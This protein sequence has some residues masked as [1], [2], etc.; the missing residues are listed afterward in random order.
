MIKIM[1]ICKGNICRSPLADEIFKDLIKK[2]NKDDVFFV[3]SCGTG[4]WHK[5]FLP[6]RRMRKLAKERG[7]IMTHRAK[8]Y[9]PEYAEEFDL[10]LVMD[11]SNKTNIL[12]V[13]D[14]KYK[15]KVKLFREYDPEGRGE[16]PDPYYGKREDFE[17]AYD[18]VERTCKNLYN[19]LLE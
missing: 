15:D 14:E 7:I 11:E 2:N 5:G 6:D 1:F 4:G 16:V 10:L 8:K 13:T 18:I 3:D 19:N 12:K 9:K 17:L